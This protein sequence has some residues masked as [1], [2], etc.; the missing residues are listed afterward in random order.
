VTDGT[1]AEARV[2]H[3]L[4]LRR[5]DEA[6]H[7]ARTALAAEPEDAGLLGALAAVLLAAGRPGDAGMRVAGATR[8][9]TADDVT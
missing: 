4:A 6:E 3:L 1:T 7:A 2:A 8:S 9:P 5:V